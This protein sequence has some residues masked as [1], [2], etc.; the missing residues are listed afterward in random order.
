MTRFPAARIILATLLPITVSAI[1]ETQALTTMATATSRDGTEIAYWVSGT[2]PSLI[3]VHGASSDHTRFAPVT[4]ALARQFTVYVMDRRG[5]GGSGDHPDYSLQAESEDILA[6]IDAADGPVF[7]LGHS[8]GGICALEAAVRSQ[9]IRRLILYEPPVA[10]PRNDDISVYQRLIA[11]G[12]LQTMLLRFLR[13]NV[14]L[15]ET[16]IEDLRAQP[17][18]PARVETARTIPREIQAVEEYK[19][20]ARVLSTLDIP[21]LLLLGGDSPEFQ[22]IGTEDLLKAIPASRMVVMPGQQHYAMLTAPVEFVREVRAF[23]EQ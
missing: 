11:D 5:R 20:D 21:T 8:F 9:R 1:A 4:E 17:T 19:L 7:L 23:L 14:R 18:W 15:S 16:E 13:E 10:A 12:K 22:R 2:G 3:L 6:V